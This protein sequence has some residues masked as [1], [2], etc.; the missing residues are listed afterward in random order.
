[1]R[2]WREST[3]TLRR[4]NIHTTTIKFLIFIRDHVACK[5]YPAQTKIVR[6]DSPPNVVD[7][8]ATTQYNKRKISK[9]RGK[10]K[11]LLKL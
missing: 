3:I 8:T 10:R 7:F 5:Q 4:K 1:M 6:T 2:I 9:M 11:I